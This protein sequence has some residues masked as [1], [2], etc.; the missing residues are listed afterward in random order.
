MDYGS[1][2]DQ[3]IKKQRWDDV[4]YAVAV[5]CDECVHTTTCWR[6]YAMWCDRL[7][8]CGIS[9]WTIPS[10]WHLTRRSIPQTSWYSATKV[11][12][13]AALS[14]LCY[15]SVC[16]SVDY[17]VYCSVSDG[18]PQ[19]FFPGVGALF[20][21][22]SIRSFLVVALK[23]QVLTV[24]ANAQN[25]LQHSQGPVPP[26]PC[27]CLRAPM[28]VGFNSGMSVLT[29]ALCARLSWLLVSF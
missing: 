1:R 6:W 25:T 28:H 5:R 23:T 24:T 2:C 14:A 10:S 4:Q 8:C 3:L 19:D 17:T 9:S 15:L 12:L 18:R 13:F 21:W 7:R 20:S 22:K 16:L 27:P 11:R 29:L 26:P